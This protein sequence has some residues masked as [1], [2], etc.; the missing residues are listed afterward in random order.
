[1]TI[2]KTNQEK[3]DTVFIKQQR[4]QPLHNYK[5]YRKLIKSKADIT[6]ER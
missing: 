2:Y 1:M 4:K 3:I 5:Q 6:N